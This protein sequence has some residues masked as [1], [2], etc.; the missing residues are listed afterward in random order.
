[1]SRRR[2]AIFRSGFSSR[3]ARQTAS[4]VSVRWI[5]H[6]EPRRVLDHHDRLRPALA[7]AELVEHAVLRHLEEPGRELAAEREPRQ[8]LE[9]TDEDLLRE[10]LRQCPI[11]DDAVHVVEDRRLVETE[12]LRERPLVATLRPAENVGVRLFEH[13]RSEYPRIC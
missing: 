8:R 10:V 11:A 3:T 7:G 9:D 12:D 13:W 5:D 6:L 4:T 1:M 2:S